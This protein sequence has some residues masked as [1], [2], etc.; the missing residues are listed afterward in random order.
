[1]RTAH[2]SPSL[3][4][5]CSRQLE[6]TQVERDTAVERRS[7]APRPGQVDGPSEVRGLVMPVTSPS[8]EPM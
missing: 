5:D 3:D 7:P 8:P 6:M 1:M 2:H 4:W